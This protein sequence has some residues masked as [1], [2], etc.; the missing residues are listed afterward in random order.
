M[1]PKPV[2]LLVL[3]A[4][5]ALPIVSQTLSP[6]VIAAAGC[7]IQTDNYRMVGTLGEPIVG[8]VRNGDFI[9]TQGFHQPDFTVTSVKHPF[10][11]NVK[12][13]VFPNPT[14]A[15]FTL[16]I[17]APE[18]QE[19]LLTLFSIEG[20]KL[21]TKQVNAQD[22]LETYDLRHQSPRL[23]VLHIQNIQSTAF[24]VAKISKT[25]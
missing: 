10:P 7:P 4:L 13:Q 2:W 8:T 22:L 15:V 23:Y 5:G 24:A 25:R 9:L 14:S 20:K 6:W 11:E 21:W 3:F 16:K 19:L 1:K 12:I 18:T 17:T